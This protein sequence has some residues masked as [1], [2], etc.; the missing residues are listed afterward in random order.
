VALLFSTNSVLISLPS[1]HIAVDGLETLA[2]AAQMAT[3]LPQMEFVRLWLLSVEL[4]I[5]TQVLA[6][7]ALQDTFFSVESAGIWPCPP[8]PIPSVHSLMDT[9]VLIVTQ[10]IIWLLESV[11]LQILGV[12]PTI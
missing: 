1:T 6:Q 12:L 11:S 8:L 5:S 7:A 2:T 10:D 9:S 4:T 3:T